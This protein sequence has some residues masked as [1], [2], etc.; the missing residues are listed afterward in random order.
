MLI[1]CLIHFRR[2]VPLL[3]VPRVFASA[4]CCISGCAFCVYDLAR[5]VQGVHRGIGIVII[6]GGDPRRRVA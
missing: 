2:P 3:I 1:Q 6:F 4:E 5:R